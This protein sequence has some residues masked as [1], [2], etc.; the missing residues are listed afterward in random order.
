M[1]GFKIKKLFPI[2]IALLAVFFIFSVAGCPNP[3][4]SDSDSGDKSLGTVDEL[5]KAMKDPNVK[6]IA[7]GADLTVSEALMLTVAK[8]L[9]ISAGKTVT[10]TDLTLGANLN[11]A[12]GTT[13]TSLVARQVADVPNAGRLVIVKLVLNTG[14]TL[15][16]AS[17]AAVELTGEAKISGSVNVAKNGSAAIGKN[18]AVTVSG[19]GDDSG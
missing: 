17:Q 2:G 15:S 13:M 7:V 3:S 1:K 10:F 18:A 11:V 12:P 5:V 8:T 14:K 19:G 4:A 9:R 6:E 16:V